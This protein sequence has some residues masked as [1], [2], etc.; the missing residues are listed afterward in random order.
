MES[1]Q[2]PAAARALE[3]YGPDDEDGFTAHRLKSILTAEE[4]EDFKRWIRHQTIKVYGSQAIYY[5]DDV[6]RWAYGMERWR[7]E[8]A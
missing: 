6:M 1:K 2:I 8:H 3:T 7:A 5:I 4:Y